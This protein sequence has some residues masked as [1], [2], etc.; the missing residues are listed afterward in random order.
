[1]NKNRRVGEEKLG[2]NIIFTITR[3]LLS[4]GRFRNFFYFF[5]F[6]SKKNKKI[7]RFSRL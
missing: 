3:Y 7:F 4:L 5:F 6:D 2:K 1:M